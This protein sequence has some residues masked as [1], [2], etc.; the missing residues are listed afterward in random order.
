VDVAQDAVSDSV[1]HRRFSDAFQF[2]HALV[3]RGTSKVKVTI[4]PD[5]QKGAPFMI[6]SIVVFFVKGA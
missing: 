1:M 3:L 2:N 5:G 4:R 6:Q